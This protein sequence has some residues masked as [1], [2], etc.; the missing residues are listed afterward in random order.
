[1]N[2]VDEQPKTDPTIPKSTAKAAKA[3]KPA[4]E[5][6]PSKEVV[7]KVA[8]VIQN[9]IPRPTVGTTSGMVWQIAEN[10][11]ESLNAPAPRK[12]V[13]A[14]TTEKGINEATAATQYGRWR[15]FH[16]LTKEI[17]LKDEGKTAA[18]VAEE[19]AEA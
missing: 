16:G 1:M 12:D 15:K 6:K 18:Q 5:A 4:K 8:K 17:I 2:N 10:I 14:V 3:P 13:I 7:A 19:A 9:G 11:S